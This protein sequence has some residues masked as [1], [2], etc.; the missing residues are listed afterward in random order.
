VAKKRFRWVR[1]T[2]GIVII[3]AIVVASASALVWSYVLP[4]ITSTATQLDDVDLAIGSAA[5][6][7]AATSQAVVFAVSTASGTATNEALT[8]ALAEAAANLDAYDQLIGAVASSGVN[9]DATQLG[10]VSLHG[11]AVIDLIQ[12]GDVDA[13]RAV[14]QENFE[15]AYRIALGQLDGARAD[16][17]SELDSVSRW[18]EAIGY[19][20]RL[21]V[22][23]AIPML[24]IF[25]FWWMARQRV[26]SYRR[27]FD[28]RIA[29]EMELT[30]EKDGLLVDIVDRFRAPLA[31]I[32]GLADVLV[33]KKQ[34]KGLDRELVVLINSE[35]AD[36]HRAVDDLLVA[37]QLQAGTLSASADIT[38]LADAIE[39]AVKPLR[40]SGIEIKVECP[41]VWVVTDREKVRH[42]LHNLLSNAVGHGGGPIFVEGSEEDGVVQ[43]LVIDHGDGLPP[44][45]WADTDDP[46]G[47]EGVLKE[48]S[49]IGLQVAYGLAG[50]IGARLDH[51]RVDDQTRFS[52]W[53]DEE[54]DGLDRKRPGRRSIIKRLPRPIRQQPPQEAGLG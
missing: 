16:L 30:R 48:P 3:L 32:R 50:L 6:S 20:V 29:E 21:T 7:R 34:I 18:S 23:L 31:S 36:L 4:N 39:D 51:Y 15:V 38:S 52:L 42:I 54:G 45:H 11:R 40:A 9:V 5:V 49:G 41:E 26:I 28:E 44:G 25:V 35:S 27:R 14:L 37:A 24:A 43:C 13:A 12:A 53:F 47:L 33:Q 17:T 2:L 10:D 22:T 19:G 46:V 1:K 8:V